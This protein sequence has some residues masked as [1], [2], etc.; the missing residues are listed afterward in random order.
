MRPVTVNV[1][2]EEDSDQVCDVLSEIAIT[3]RG[4]KR[5][6]DMMRS[7]L[8]LWGVDRVDAGVVT[9]AGQIVCTDSG[10][11][12][13]QREFNRRL[14]IRFK[15]L[16]L[17]IATPVSTVYNHVATEAPAPV[18]QIENAPPPNQMAESPPPSALGNTS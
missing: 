14:M 10:R 13:V 16:G 1:P 6:A 2:I 12:A 7:D 9:I 15:E 17:R 8:Q 18:Q 11:W 5:F 3:M 4:E